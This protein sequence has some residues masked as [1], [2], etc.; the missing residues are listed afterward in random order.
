MIYTII[1]ITTPLETRIYGVALDG[2]DWEQSDIPTHLALL[3]EVATS[4]GSYNG[5]VY[6]DTDEL[7]A[8]DIVSVFDVTFTPDEVERVNATV[9]G[10][11]LT[12][13]GLE[14]PHDFQLNRKILNQY[15]R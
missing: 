13:R 5:I 2:S 8:P 4:A 15:R 1:D 6:E 3:D 10:E 7:Y 14:E 11:E 12:G 9:E